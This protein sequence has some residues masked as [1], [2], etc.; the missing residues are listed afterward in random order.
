MTTDSEHWDANPNHYVKWWLD[1]V[2]QGILYQNEHLKS[3]LDYRHANLFHFPP[4]IRNE[5]RQHINDI[6]NFYTNWMQ[7]M[8]ELSLNQWSIASEWSER[9]AH[10]AQKSAG[11]KTIDN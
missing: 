11:I 2:H 6:A 3:K 5:D 1:A 10:L 7:Y 9:M 8:Y 4:A